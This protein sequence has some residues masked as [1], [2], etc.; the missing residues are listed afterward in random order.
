MSI[1]LPHVT[2]VQKLCMVVVAVVV[3][4]VGGRFLKCV[5]GLKPGVGLAVRVLA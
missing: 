1:Y 5:P 3:V 4:V 2:G